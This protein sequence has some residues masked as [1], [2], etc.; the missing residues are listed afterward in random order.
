MHVPSVKSMLIQSSMFRLFMDLLIVSMLS[1]SKHVWNSILLVGEG[2][3]HVR[4]HFT[5]GGWQTCKGKKLLS[6]PTS[7]WSLSESR[8]ALPCLSDL[9][10]KGTLLV[11]NVSFETQ[12]WNI[13]ERRDYSIMTDYTVCTED[14]FSFRTAC[15]TQ[16]KGNVRVPRTK[17]H[18]SWVPDLYRQSPY[19]P[20]WRLCAKHLV[21]HH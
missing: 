14:S 19:S 20:W 6:V 5:I 8:E 12:S 13:H 16:T 3:F 9:K 21:F 10:P 1:W 18:S 15:V 11:R 17:P 4:G 2:R 7:D